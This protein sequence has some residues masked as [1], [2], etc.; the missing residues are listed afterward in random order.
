[1]GI[2]A[3]P[4]RALTRPPSPRQLGLE[5]RGIFSRRPTEL[6]RV[7]SAELRGARITDRE[8]HVRDGIALREHTHARFLQGVDWTKSPISLSRTPP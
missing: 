4:T 7:F 8:R 1:M 5:P 3:A 2:V 6:A